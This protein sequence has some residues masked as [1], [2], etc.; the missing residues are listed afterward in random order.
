MRVWMHKE[1]G[2]LA[3]ARGVWLET[4][5]PEI[6]ET[7]HTIQFTVSQ[8]TWAFENKFGVILILPK[9]VARQN[10]I[11]KEEHEKR[12][13]ELERLEAELETLK[14]DYNFEH[15]KRRELQEQLRTAREVIELCASNGSPSAKRW[16]GLNKEK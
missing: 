10:E 4:D 7:G 8:S 5:L 6:N 9:K 1:T 3:V 16:L 12:C 15:D 11:L 13:D 14:A 2:E